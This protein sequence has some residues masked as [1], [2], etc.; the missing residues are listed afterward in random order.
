MSALALAAFCAGCLT[1]ASAA[2]AVAAAAY[3][4]ARRPRTEVPGPPTIPLLGNVRLPIKLP[5]LV[6]GLVDCH[7]RYGEI[8]R[9]Y[10]GHKLYIVISRPEDARKVLTS[11]KT[12]ERDPYCMHVMRTVV[13]DGLITCNGD[14]WKRHRKAIDPAFHPKAL[15]QLV[16]TFN[17]S[18]RV[19]CEK[20]AASA[21]AT[22]DVYPLLMASALHSIVKAI[23]GVELDRLEPDTTKH[24]RIAEIRKMAATFLRP[25]KTI[26]GVMWLSAEGRELKKHM[27]DFR[28]LVD[29]GLAMARENM[30]TDGITPLIHFLWDQKPGENLSEEEIYNEIRTLT[31]SGVETTATSLGFTLALLGLHPEWQRLAQA[32]LD[33]VFSAGDR[34][35]PATERDL[36]QL[37]VIDAIVKESLRLFPPVP[38]TVY[39]LSDDVALGGGR[40]VAPRGSSVLV[41]FLLMHRRP[42]LFPEPLQ[43]DPGRFL[44]GGSATRR[45]P[46]SYLP[47]GGGPRRCVGAR[48][49]DV[50]MRVLL[51]AVLRRFRV[52]PGSSRHQLEQIPCSVTAHPLTGFR[53]SC[54]PRNDVPLDSSR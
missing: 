46:D 27:A 15:T 31:V 8:F 32:E 39:L 3:L 36:S 40:L 42:D 41:S 33:D 43:F 18:G 14:T 6:H 12:R 34:L 25:W 10:L 51:A 1:L 11:S 48:F 22:V 5:A 29:R 50:E 45:R 28:R 19:L 54:V 37:T 35:R 24:S 13:S 44:A 49:A 20:L 17:E 26:K 7:Q 4:W 53:I 23:F 21:G 52:L 16:D 30:K 2:V 38:S 9:Y 47:F